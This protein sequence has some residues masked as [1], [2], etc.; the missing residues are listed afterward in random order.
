MRV[1]YLYLLTI[2]IFFAIDMI[3]LGFLAR[4]FYRDNL[5][6]LMRPDIN[7]FAAL[8]FYLLYIAGIMIF[9]TMPSLEKNSLRMAVVL[10]GLFGFFAYATYDL[11]NLATLKGWPLNVVVVDIIWGVVLTA[12]VAA[13]SFLIGR[14]LIA[15]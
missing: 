7:W 3:W 4:G 9:A 14:W 2:P 13:A 8:V 11:T 6:H 1:V 5:G 10:G 12:S 15:Y